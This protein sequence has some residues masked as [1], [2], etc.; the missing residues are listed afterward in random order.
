MMISIVLLSLVLVMPA[1]SASLNLVIVADRQT[2]LYDVGNTVTFTGSVSNGSTVPDALVL[3]EVDTPKQKPWIIRTFTTGQTPVGPWPVQLLGVT[4]TDQYGNPKY[5]FQEGQD[6]GFNV[7]VR[8]N[9]GSTCPVVVTIN[10]FFSNGLPFALQP[11][12]NTTLQPGQLWSTVTWPVNI[13]VS[14]VVG[15]AMVC[16]SVFN[17]YP[18][19]NGLPYS[20]EMSATFNIVSG[21][22]GQVSQAS[23]SGTFNFTVPLMSTSSLPI[24]LGN[25]TVY[26][27]TH[28]GYSFASAHTIFTLKLFGDFSG[29]GKIDMKDVAVVARAFGSHPGSPNWN[30]AADLTGPVPLVPDGVV[31]MRDVALVSKAFGT[32]ANTDP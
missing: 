31:D 6:A 9:S 29:D 21:I 27:M 26:A 15:Q 22:P 17:D 3:F 16:A 8:N 10:V 20:P 11:V 14:S 7:T 32:I 13:P 30:P 18:K 2:A 1:Y 28:Y 24:M 19:N 25:Y 12:V 23:T 4:P 5:S